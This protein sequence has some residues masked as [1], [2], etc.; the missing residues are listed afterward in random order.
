MNMRGL[1]ESQIKA[2]YKSGIGLGYRVSVFLRFYVSA[3]PSVPSRPFRRC[4]AV[5]LAKKLYSQNE[6]I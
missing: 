4:H 1:P 2:S 6:P 3:F 5:T